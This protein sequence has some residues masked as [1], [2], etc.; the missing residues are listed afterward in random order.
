MFAAAAV[1]LAAAVVAAGAV[2]PAT[3]IGQGPVRDRISVSY[4][5]SGRVATAYH[6]TPPNPGGGPDHDYARDT[7]TQAW[8][9]T[10]THALSVAGCAAGGRCGRPVDLVGATGSEH[11][12]GTIDHKHVDGIYRIDNASEHCQ[13]HGTA[14]RGAALQP[15]LEVALSQGGRAITV[16]AENPV[17]EALLLL[18]TTCPGQ[19]DSLDGLLNNYFTPGFS[20]SAAY[21]PDRW[22]A[23][24]P[25]TISLSSLRPGS[26]MNIKL[27]QTA[28]GTPPRNCA[29]VH[30]SYE[31]CTTT[32][33]WSGML[34]LRL[35]G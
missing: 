17:E 32:G 7:S 33:S 20:F 25:V 12:S 11:A 16:I 28:A 24:A 18:P 8:S 19:G 30:P 21:G 3:P 14:P 29:V 1:K 10:F 4:A 13:V 9:Y 34:T 2:Q 22:F 35:S 27:R 26:A 23:A 15:V 31:H 6:S 5:G